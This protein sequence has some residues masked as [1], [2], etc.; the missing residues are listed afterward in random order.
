MKKIVIIGG[1]IAGL[2]AGVYGLLAGYDVAIYEK[3][4]IAGGQCTGWNRKGYHIDNCIHWLTGT[5]KDTDLRKEWETVGALSPDSKFSKTEAFYTSIVGDKR[6][7]LWNDLERTEKELLEIAPEDEAEIKKFIEHVRYA[8]SC[9]I[10]SK[11]PMDMMGIR[12]YI[13]M[14]K[15][16]TDMPKV[17]KEYGEIELE[18]L[19]ARFKNPVLRKLFCDYMPKE[20]TA[21]SLLVSYATMTSGNGLIPEGGS[22]AMTNRMVERFKELG[23]KLVCNAS[24]KRIIIEKKMAC[25]IELENGEKIMADYVISA[26]DTNVLFEKLIGEKYMDKRWKEVYSDYNRFPL[27]SG[28]QMAFAI[29]QSAYHEKDTVVFSCEPFMIGEQKVDRMSVKSFE[30]EETF[31]PA[32]K[33]VLQANVVQTDA[34]FLYWKSLTKEE[35]QQKKQELVEVVMN[36]IL[37]MFPELEGHMEFLDCWTPLT[38]QRYCNAYH[39]AYMSFITRKGEKAFRVKGTIKGIKNLYIASQWINA[40]GGLPVALVAGKFAVQRI[41]KKEKRPYLEF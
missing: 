38:Y 35:Y 29:D 24:V 6:A 17:M 28:F 39:G 13:E 36:R 12:D 33:T 22:L 8:Q 27:T 4:P 26:A 9:Q 37:S 31:A 1:G 41:L 21:S 20:Y 15:G 10:P 19:S 3:N 5:K 7:T 16:M 40:P 30:Y 11:K 2:S 25:G 14:G 23:G 34:D 32:G 18:D